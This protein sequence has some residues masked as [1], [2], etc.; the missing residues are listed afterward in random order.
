MSIQVDK[1]L[2]IRMGQGPTEEQLKKMKRDLRFFPS[3]NTNP[4]NLSSEQVEEFNQNGYLKGIQIFSESEIKEYRSFFDDHLEQVMTSKDNNTTT[5]HGGKV[6][7]NYSITNGHLRFGDVYDLLVHP[8]IVGIVRDLIG[9]DIIGW[10]CHYFCK[11]PNDGKTVAWHQDA[12]YWPQT[13][14]K[15]ISVWLAIDDSDIENGCMR[16]VSGSHLHGPVHY[17]FSEPHENNVLYA[18]VDEA[19]KY[20]DI[21]DIELSAG[22][23]SIHSDLLLHSS[24]YNNSSRRRC[25]IAL[26]YNTT[27]VRIGTDFSRFYNFTKFINYFG[28][29]TYVLFSYGK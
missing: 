24:H 25:G 26:R 22:K 14:S 13:P 10:G 17:R 4:S 1:S 7:D 19:D 5:S 6:P 20:G 27:D 3:T 21:V 29:L 9:N 16:F 12:P 23:I 28:S 18:T 15:T 8:R 11:L 2:I